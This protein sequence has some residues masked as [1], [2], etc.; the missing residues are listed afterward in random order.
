VIQ[1]RLSNQQM[2][3]SEE[4]KPV[5]RPQRSYPYN[6]ANQQAPVMTLHGTT[7]DS[8]DDFELAIDALDNQAKQKPQGSPQPHPHRISNASRNR[9]SS[10]ALIQ[11]HV[12]LISSFLSK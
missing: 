1:A 5:T 9:T 7:K 3:Q 8:S 6:I 11:L 4:P 2:V 10:Q 12:C